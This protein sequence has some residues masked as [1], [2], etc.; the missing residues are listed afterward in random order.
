MQYSVVMG[1]VDPVC[2]Q[3]S[4][5]NA[6]DRVVPGL[7]AQKSSCGIGGSSSF[8][9]V[10]RKIIIMDAILLGCGDVLGT[11]LVDQHWSYLATPAGEGGH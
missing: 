6:E 8:L 2:G 1:H 5:H 9:S 7:E 11:L 10:F 4:L 3:T